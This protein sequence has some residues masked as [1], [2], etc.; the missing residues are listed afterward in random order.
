MSLL[1]LFLAVALQPADTT[2]YL[3]LGY[4]VIWLV[5]FIYFAT[6]VSRQR[7]VKQDLHLLRQLL[8]EEENNPKQSV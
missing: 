7:N 2:P 3:I 6:L 1:N 8:E 4:A 5:G